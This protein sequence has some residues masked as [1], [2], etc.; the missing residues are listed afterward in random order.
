METCNWDGNQFTIYPPNT[1]WN[2][3][4]GLYIFAKVDSSRYWRALYIGSTDSLSNRLSHH[5]RWD[6]ALRQGMTHIHA[7]VESNYTQRLLL[8]QHLVQRFNPPMNQQW[9]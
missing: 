3:V 2:N 5:E 9:T 4:P 6:E 8:E 7:R 1:A